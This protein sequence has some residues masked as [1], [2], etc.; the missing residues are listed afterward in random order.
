M[1]MN[2]HEFEEGY[3]AWLIQDDRGPLDEQLQA[4]RVCCPE[5]DD[6]AARHEDIERLFALARLAP[7]KDP[8]VPPWAVEALGLALEGKLPH[9]RP[10][11]WRIVA[12]RWALALAP[13]FL[14]LWLLAAVPADAGAWG[15]AFLCI[16]SYLLLVNDIAVPRPA[17]PAR[18]SDS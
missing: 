9:E 3:L 15:A 10:T 7:E 1:A 14:A 4:H 16:L 5:C 13:V 18:S 12:G 17:P 2:C 11:T 6:L 8:D